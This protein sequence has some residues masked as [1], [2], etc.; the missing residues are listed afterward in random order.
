NNKPQAVIISIRDYAELTRAREA[1]ALL[2]SPEAAPQGAGDA[3]ANKLTEEEMRFFL[4]GDAEN[5]EM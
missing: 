2:D 1:L 5:N 4:R 3:Y